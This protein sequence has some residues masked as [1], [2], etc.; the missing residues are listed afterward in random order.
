M[1]FGVGVFGA[2]GRSERVDVLERHREALAFELTADGET[3]FLSEKVAR[4][5][6]AAVVIKRNF[7][8]RQSGRF[9]HFA[10]AFAVAVGENGRVNVHESVILQVGVNCHCGNATDAEHSLEEVG[11]GAQISLLA[12][13]FA[14][15]TLGLNG[16]FVGR[17][18]E[19]SYLLRFDFERL[20][21]GFGRHD[22]SEHL[23]RRSV[24]KFRNLVEIF[25]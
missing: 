23:Y 14:G 9:E 21:F 11:S 4:I 3:D 13:K 7:I 12:Q 19:K 2:E 25:G 24:F 1:S 16:E 5:V 17:V 15:V 8:E 18:A 22:F 6:H 20:T 10:R